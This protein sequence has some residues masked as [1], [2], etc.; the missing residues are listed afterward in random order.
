MLSTSY[1]SRKWRRDATLSN[2]LNYLVTSKTLSLRLFVA[3]QTPLQPVTKT[4]AALLLSSSEIRGGRQLGDLPRAHA[5]SLAH[6]A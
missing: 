1:C 4:G 6:D 5:A 2:L 3:R